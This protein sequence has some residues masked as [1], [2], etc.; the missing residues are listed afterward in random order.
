MPPPAPG[1]APCAA[2]DEE[3]AQLRELTASLREQLAARD[4]EVT[5]LKDRVSRLERAASRNGGNSSMPP[6]GDDLPGR[7]PPRKQRRAAER[8]AAKKKRKR[9]KQPGAPGSAMTWADPDETRD[10]YPEGTCECGADLDGAEDLGVA[11]SY[12]QNEVPEPKAQTVQHDLHE[13][14]C[15]CGKTHIAP[16]PPGVPDSAVSIGPRLRALAVYLLVFQHVPV[17]RCRLLLSDVAG[18]DV[19]DGFARSCL[20]K[21]ASM[22]AGTIKLIKTLI[23]ASKVVGFD[24]TTLRS[25]A[26]GQKKYIH[27]A[28]TEKYSLFHLGTRSLETMKDFGILP[29][30]AGIAV[31]DRYGNYFHARRANLSGHQACVQHLLRDLQDCAE[32]CPG[33][34]WPG[35]A[36]EALPGLIHARNQASD[37]GLDGSPPAPA[38]PWRHSSAA[39]SPSASPPCPASPGRRTARNSTPDGTCRSSAATAN[40][41]F[42]GSPQTWTCGP[43]TTSA[44]ADFGRPR[45]SSGPPGGSPATTPPRTASTSAATSTPPANT[46]ATS[47]PSC[48]P[49]SLGT[50]GCRPPPIGPDQRTSPPEISHPALPS[51][52]I[53]H[54]GECLPY[55]T[56]RRTS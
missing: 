53:N 50:P 41:T 7:K 21:A 22:A 29:D 23:I 47:S 16:R 12:Q 40:A 34:I 56:S 37:A 39:P 24:E 25:G 44:N 5:D 19:S 17:E 52:H 31:T 33:A 10:W 13:T 55:E 20:A 4:A 35:Q 15:A 32:T 8:E 46:D 28:F 45:S 6:S 48:T 11:R 18:A 2:R 1:C 30:F 54:T 14:R 51:N 43:R 9:G 27:G 26:A 38:S 49:C 3:I 36:Q 42:S